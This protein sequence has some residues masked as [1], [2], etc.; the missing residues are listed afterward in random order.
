MSPA[1]FRAALRLCFV[2]QADAARGLGLSLPLIDKMCSGS[3]RISPVTV[4]KLRDRWRALQQW[5]T[6]PWDGNLC[7]TDANIIRAIHELN[8]ET[9]RYY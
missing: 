3:R 9:P 2:T 5:S 6:G 7:E 8:R 4:G 1:T